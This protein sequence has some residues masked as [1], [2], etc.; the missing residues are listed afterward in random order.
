MKLPGQENKR[1][2]VVGMG[3]DDVW[4]L[5]V[6]KLKVCALSGQPKVTVS[7]L[8]VV[9]VVVVVVVVRRSP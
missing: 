4:I 1:V 2:V 7:R 5:E 6:P 3:I 8:G 9:V